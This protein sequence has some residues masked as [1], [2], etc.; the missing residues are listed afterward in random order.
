[1][2]RKSKTRRKQKGGKAGKM[3]RILDFS[4]ASLVGAGGYGI[5]LKSKTK[6]FKLLRDSNACEEL[7]KETV[8]QQK[9]HTL[10]AQISEVVIPH[11]WY[12]TSEILSYNSMPYLCGIEMDYL[13]PPEGF[14]EQV[15]ILLG[16]KGD[17]ID[18]EWGVKTSEPVSN[19]NPTRGFFASPE[20]LE[21]I[22]QEEESSMTIEKVSYIMGKSLRLLLEGGI[23][24][25]DLEWV[26]TNGKL[27]LLDFGL[28]ELGKVD[29]LI[30]LN[31]SSWRGLAND[32][33][34][35]HEGNR[36]YKEFMNGFFK[37]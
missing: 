18:S 4:N 26:W 1:M 14:S 28:C 36:G 25:I 20:T 29:P 19:T 35:P 17:D 9:A 8:I 6:V 33:Y 13:P 11:I 37:I 24:P 30:F 32:F 5:I 12:T 23:L 10:L 31:D 16:Y 7:K 21:L 27:G 34:I 22:W 15:H 3:K 2:K